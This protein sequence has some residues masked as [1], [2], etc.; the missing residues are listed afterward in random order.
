MHT[1]CL[2]FLQS[3][4]TEEVVT[5]KRILEL[6]SFNVNG[7]ARDIATSLVPQLYHGIDLQP[8]TGYVDEVADVSKIGS[9]HDNQWDVVISTEMLEHCLD[10]R[11]AIEGMKRAC[12]DGGL[13]VVTARGP[14]KEY[15]GYPD[16]YWR[17]T[18]GDFQKMF[19]DFDVVSLLEDSGEPGVF[20]VGRKKG[21]SSVDLASIAP[22]KAPSKPV[23]TVTQRNCQLVISTP[24]CIVPNGI[25][26]TRLEHLSPQWHRAR[27][28]LQI[29]YGYNA[30]EVAVDGYEVGE[31]RNLVVQKA[32]EAGAEFVFFIDSDVLVPPNAFKQ[33][34]YRLKVTHPEYDI[35]AGVYCVKEHPTIPIIYRQWGEGPWWDWKLGDVIAPVVGVPMGCTLLRLKYF[36]RMPKDLPWFKTHD[37]SD[38]NPL[39]NSTD[40]LEVCGTVT[41]DLWH[42]KLAVERAGV[43]I[44]VDGSVICG[45]QN[46]DTGEI[47][48]LPPDCPP[49]VR[50]GISAEGLS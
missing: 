9:Q 5:G 22:Q 40:G 12:V 23:T 34:M 50:A 32:I 46:R 37:L 39:D 44:L 48:N 16:D 43:K 7:S 8:Q 2:E 15:H 3:V 11:S 19:A 17:F 1:S 13:L 42:C 4:L 14:G 47:F 41:E 27:Q 28:K 25:G 18:V 30:A 20:F 45:H 29:P 10:W 6:G 31:A 49:V 26:G 38:G 24:I 21:K 36:E 33:L 35:A